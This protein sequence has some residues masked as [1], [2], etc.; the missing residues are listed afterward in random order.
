[1]CFGIRISSPFHLGTLQTPIQ[2]QKCLKN[3][4]N[5]L[6]RPL[7]LRLASEA[8]NPSNKYFYWFSDNFLVFL[9]L[10]EPFK[11]LPMFT[12]QTLVD[13]TNYYQ[14]F[15]WSMLSIG[16]SNCKKVYQDYV[17][18]RYVPFNWVAKGPM[19]QKFNQINIYQICL[20]EAHL[21]Q[22]RDVCL[23]NHEALQLYRCKSSSGQLTSQTFIV[24]NYFN[25]TC[26]QKSNFT[27]FY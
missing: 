22:E 27:F 17:P 23:N 26:P 19:S 2:N 10:P 5:V 4:N 9:R 13:S 6:L 1:M 3:A 18:F 15:L 12:I 14:E 20:C 7:T 24:I 11:V 8:H 21:P 16:L 25:W